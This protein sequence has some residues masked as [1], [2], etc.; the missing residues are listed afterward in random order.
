MEEQIKKLEDMSLNAWPSHQMELYDGWILRFSYFYTH[1]TNSVEQFGTSTLPW[2]EKIPY[3]ESVYRRWGTPAILKISP[4][5]SKD[6]DY[7]LENRG[8]EIQHVTNVMTVDLNQADLS[9]P[10]PD[11]EVKA[12]I[13]SYWIEGLLNLKKTTNGPFPKTLSVSASTGM[14]PLSEQV[15]ASWT[16][17]MWASTPS[18]STRTSAVRDWPDRSVPAS[19]R[20][21]GKPAP[22]TPIFR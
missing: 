8:Y 19:F 21:E 11:T 17:T 14:M 18:M 15:W 3:C 13:P 2:R 16:V 6:F 5:V 7:V 12:R 10:C 9:C 1:R 22:P 4:L 20:R